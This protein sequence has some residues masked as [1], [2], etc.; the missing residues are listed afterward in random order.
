MRGL[1]KPSQS[2]KPF[3]SLPKGYTFIADTDININL[4]LIL[5]FH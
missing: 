5:M 1:L 3:P 2:L 4:S